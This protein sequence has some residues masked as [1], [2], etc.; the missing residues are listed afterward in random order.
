MG[1]Q[2]YRMHP[3]ANTGVRILI[4]TLNL[5]SH[6]MDR[7]TGAAAGLAAGSLFSQS[8]ASAPNYEATKGARCRLLCSVQ[9]LRSDSRSSVARKALARLPR[10]EPGVCRDS[11]IACNE[12]RWAM[13]EHRTADEGTAVHVLARSRMAVP[14]AVS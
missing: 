7:P 2:M 9:R 8:T 3:H 12:T 6:F 5:P 4:Q 1:H 11:Y 13:R 10:G 14:C